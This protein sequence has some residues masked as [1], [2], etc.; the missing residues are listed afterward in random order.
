MMLA[1]V[2]DKADMFWACARL[3]QLNY[4]IDLPEVSQLRLFDDNTMGLVID[5]AIDEPWRKEMMADAQKK[6]A[7]VDT[8]NAW[9]SLWRGLADS[10]QSTDP[11]LQT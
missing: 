4:R 2:L 1:D 5:A 9:V 6:T 8:R 10:T 7:L 11:V 3:L